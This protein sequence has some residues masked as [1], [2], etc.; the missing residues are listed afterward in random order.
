MLSGGYI[1]LT[2]PAISKF[3]DACLVDLE[4][5]LRKGE[6]TPSSTQKSHEE[7]IKSRQTLM[8][9]MIVSKVFMLKKFYE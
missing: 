8:I 4:V 6:I 7:R 9:G 1:N 5:R 3:I 2:E